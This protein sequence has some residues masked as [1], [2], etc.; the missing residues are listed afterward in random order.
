MLAEAARLEA[1]VIRRPLSTTN[2][3][4]TAKP[5]RR[6]KMTALLAYK[7]LAAVT[8]LLMLLTG[9]GGSVVLAAD[10]L[11]GDLLYPVKLVME[12]VRLFLT[13]D[14]ADRAELAMTFAGQ[15]IEEMQRLATQGELVPDSVIARLTHQMEETMAQIAKARPEEVPALL[16]RV[17]KRTRA[18]QQV[19]EQVRTVA[20]EEAQA[21]LCRASEVMERAH[22][23]ARA[24]LSDPQ[25]FREEY[26]Y[27]YEG[28]RGP[29]GE[30]SPSP[31]NEP[32]QL[33]EEYQYRYEGTPGPHV[34]ASPSPMNEPQ[35][36]QEEHQYRNEGTPGPHGEGS[37]SPT[38]TPTST[39][40]HERGG[41]SGRGH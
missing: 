20:R 26:Q 29:H 3:V 28:T 12:D 8:A 1:Q 31:M 24:G 5:E 25:R 7:I 2:K 4:E 39:D 16:E 27:R 13:A 9:A 30:A 14:P 38:D 33:Q 17:M 40:G 18:Q 21:A 11:P 10:S 32:Q 22:Q 19:L 15:R 6:R 23:S 41:H 35:Q 36:S 37:P 34:E